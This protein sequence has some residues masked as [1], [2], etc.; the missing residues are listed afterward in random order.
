MIH[1]SVSA[2][3]A[4]RLWLWGATVLFPAWW[5]TALVLVTQ[6]SVADTEEPPPCL[7]GGSAYWDTYGWGGSHLTFESSC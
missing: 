3:R 4:V 2:R 7:G 6:P 5:F 1:P